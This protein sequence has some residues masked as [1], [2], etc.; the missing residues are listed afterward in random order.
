MFIAACLLIYVYIAIFLMATVLESAVLVLF[1]ALFTAG[2]FFALRSVGLCRT[3]E[4][5]VSVLFILCLLLALR[6]SFFNYETLDYKNFL[7]HWM[8]YYRTN[9]GFSALAHDV[10]NYNVPYL[11]FLSVFSYIG[12]S[13]LYMIKLLSVFFDTVLAFSLTLVVSHFTRSKKTLALCFLLSMVMPTVLLNGSLWGQCDSIYAS[14][15]VLCVFFGLKEKPVSCVAMAA[16]S[17]AFKLQG[18]FILPVLILLLIK[19]RI[20]LIHLVAFPFVYYLAVSPAVIA[21]RPVWDTITFYVKNADSVGSGLNYNSPSVFSLFYSVSDTSRAAAAG[22]AAAFLLCLIVFVVFFVFRKKASDFALLTASMIIVL[23]IPMFLPHMH[24]RYFFI[25][26]ILVLAIA[27]IKPIAVPAVPLI[28]FASLLGY[29]AYLKQ[30]YL[31]SMS[32]GFYALVITLVCLGA[33]FVSEL[34]YPSRLAPYRHRGQTEN[35]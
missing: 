15:A 10:G 33:I 20:R 21:G 25:A 35:E 28:S 26:D 14:F 31:L 2:A 8:D 3:V 16:L 1:F 29:H 32:I 12:F 19:R 11:V 4:G 7:S 6:M 27:L 24:E 18:I 5:A 22:I 23:G 9:N 30:R 13:D 17:I 34:K